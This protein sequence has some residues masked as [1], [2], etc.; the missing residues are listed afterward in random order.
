MVDL[1]LAIYMHPPHQLSSGPSTR[2][3]VGMIEDFAGGIDADYSD[4]LSTCARRPG[5]AGSEED[6]DSGYRGR[7]RRC[8]DGRKTNRNRPN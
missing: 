3:P 2:Q 4:A 8:L 1:Q 6:K 7:Y 5:L